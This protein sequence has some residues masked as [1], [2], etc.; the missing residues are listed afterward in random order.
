MELT[1]LDGRVT[2]EFTE[3]VTLKELSWSPG[4]YW[5]GS[6]PSRG[7]SQCKA[8]SMEACSVCL[9]TARRLG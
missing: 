3:D 1:N 6:V 8:L 9:G 5:G 2:V 4:M 7:S